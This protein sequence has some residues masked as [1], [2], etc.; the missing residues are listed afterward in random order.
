VELDSR[1]E[2][3]A[4]RNNA[5]D[6]REKVL[7]EREKALTNKQKGTMNARPN[8]TVISPIYWPVSIVSSDP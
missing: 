7:D 1:E 3:S 2:E 8:P 6:E 4:E 5:L